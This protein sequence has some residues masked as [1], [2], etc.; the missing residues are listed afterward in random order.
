MRETLEKVFEIEKQEFLEAPDS[1]YISRT[2]FQPWINSMAVDY[3]VLQINT[4]A[5]DWPDINNKV[6]VTVELVVKKRPFPDNVVLG[7]N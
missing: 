4:W 6:R 3:D 5:D 2:Y 1:Y 7:E